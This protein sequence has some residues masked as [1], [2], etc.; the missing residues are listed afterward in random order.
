MFLLL[1]NLF[2]R[3]QP[4]N[5]ARM[6]NKYSTSSFQLEKKNRTGHSM[7]GPATAGMLAVLCNV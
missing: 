2:N 1:G 7:S 5:A 3:G 4:L 6:K